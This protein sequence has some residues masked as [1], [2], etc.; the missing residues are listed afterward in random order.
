MC[1][2][3]MIKRLTYPMDAKPLPIFHLFLKDA[4]LHRLLQMVS[5]PC[6]GRFIFE[7][8]QTGSIASI[9]IMQ[10]FP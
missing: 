10:C 5:F 1:N 8:L 7:E 4:V 3:N 9:R 2:I 6:H